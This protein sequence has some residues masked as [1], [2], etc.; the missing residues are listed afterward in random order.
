MNFCNNS[1]ARPTGTINIHGGISLKYMITPLFGPVG[2]EILIIIAVLILLF[3]ASRIPKV[4]RSFGKTFGSFKK[5]RAEIEEEIN[6]MK[7]EGSEVKRD[8][9]NETSEA[10]SDINNEANEAVRETVD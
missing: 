5:G 1:N 7:N 3:G 10:V 4:A 2:P 8:I 9:E 6:T